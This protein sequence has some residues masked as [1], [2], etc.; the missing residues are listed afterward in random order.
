M[1]IEYFGLQEDPFIIDNL[2][3]KFF[4]LTPSHADSV[5]K[6]EYAIRSKSGLAVIYGDVGT[7]KTTILTDLVNRFVGNEI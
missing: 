3:P 1:Y 2:D 4:Y 6:C 5:A 7:G